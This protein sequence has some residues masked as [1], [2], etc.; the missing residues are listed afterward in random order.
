M[1][2]MARI[3][4]SRTV[5]AHIAPALYERGFFQIE[6]GGPDLNIS[7]QGSSF[8]YRVSGR[9][10]VRINIWITDLEYPSLVADCTSHSVRAATSDAAAAAHANEEFAG[11]NIA[12]ERVIS[13]PLFDDNPKLPNGLVMI[14]WLLQTRYIL[15]AFI[16][17]IVSGFQS[18]ANARPPA[19]A[20]RF[21]NELPEIEHY[22]RTA[23]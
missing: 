7:G 21:L 15:S 19:L 5:T 20:R 1:V 3:E 6:N 12:V 17:P 22:V 14:A 9:S 4:M 18:R 2:Q 16:A 11:V 10:I 23:S 13:I 8:F